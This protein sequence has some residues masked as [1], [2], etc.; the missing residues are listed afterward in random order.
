MSLLKAPQLAKCLSQKE[1][2]GDTGS[3]LG[4][5][6]QSQSAEYNKDNGFKRGSCSKIGGIE[7][8]PFQKGRQL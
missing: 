1:F 2:S 3:G 4:V 5:L 6:G 8:V 7:N